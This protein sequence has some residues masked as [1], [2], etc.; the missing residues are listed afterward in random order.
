MRAKCVNEGGGWGWVGY[1]VSTPAFFH[2]AGLHL[3]LYARIKPQAPAEFPSR[4]P[5]A[6]QLPVARKLREFADAEPRARNLEASSK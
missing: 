1:F 4:S 2:S 3:R 6:V 5:K